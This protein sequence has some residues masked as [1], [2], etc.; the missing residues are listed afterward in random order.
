MWST[1]SF[2]KFH[3]SS[4]S[5]VRAGILVNA[6]DGVEDAMMMVVRKRNELGSDSRLIRAFAFSAFSVN[7]LGKRYRHS[8]PTHRTLVPVALSF[9]LQNQL[10]LVVCLL[11]SFES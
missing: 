5:A 10:K 2:K 11:P 7:H 3:V 1:P 4:R 6:L 8:C 9:H